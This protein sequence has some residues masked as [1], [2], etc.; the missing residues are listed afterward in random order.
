MKYFVFVLLVL[1]LIMVAYDLPPALPS[2]FYG[3]VYGTTAGTVKAVIDVDGEGVVIAITTIFK[4][5]G[6]PVYAINVPMDGIA[7]G[8]PVRFKIG[9]QNVGR[10]VLHS[11]T[12]VNVDLRKK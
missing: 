12:N 7:E 4:H 9:T 8:T 2:S 3:R 11:G 10:S 5:D 1:S 6:Y